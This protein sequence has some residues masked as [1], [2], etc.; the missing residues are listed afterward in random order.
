MRHSGADDSQARF[1]GMVHTHHHLKPLI[2]LLEYA[3]LAGN[4]EMVEF[5]RSGY[6]YARSCG[7]PTIGY[8]AALPGPDTL[9]Y[10]TVQEH[11]R[12]AAEGCTV[13]DYTALGLKLS[14]A[15][16]GD[17]WDDVDRCARNHFFESQLL[18]LDWVADLTRDL[19]LSHVA[20]DASAH[21]TG[22]RVLERSVGNF[23]SLPAP[24]ACAWATAGPAC[25]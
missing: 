15:G 25:G 14:Q 1:L 20:P 17:Y 22:D 4:R 8:I 24:T 10:A 3:L 18:S 21:E 2:G 23:A 11:I 19:E 5:A 6:E 16:L 9:S 7:S 12:H 13:A